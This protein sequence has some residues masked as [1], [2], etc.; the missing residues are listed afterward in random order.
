MSPETDE[1]F[2]DKIKESRDG[3]F[4]EYTPRIET[5]PYAFLGL[6]FNPDQP[7]ISQIGELME[8]ELAGSLGFACRCMSV[9]STAPATSSTSSRSLT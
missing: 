6:V 8:K 4:A 7:P 3:Y 5:M 9:L 2:R 1:V